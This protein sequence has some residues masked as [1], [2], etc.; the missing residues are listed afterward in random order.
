MRFP[1][2]QAVARS[3][4]PPGFTFPHHN[5]PGGGT[6]QPIKNA[7]DYWRCDGCNALPGGAYKTDMP[8]SKTDPM[9]AER[10][11]RRA[12]EM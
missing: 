10:R 4:W 6:L 5:C 9:E 8:I 2:I 3:P 7:P 1:S 11:K 12:A